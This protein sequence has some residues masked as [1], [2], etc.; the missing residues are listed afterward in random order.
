MISLI[1][2]LLQLLFGGK[3]RPRPTARPGRPAPIASG[4]AAPA[5]PMTP[6]AAPERAA[7]IGPRLQA[8]NL[9]PLA[10]SEL[11]RSLRQRGLSVWSI[12]GGASWWGRRDL[13][14]PS[15]DERTNL[16]D[17]GMIGRG[18]ASADELA[19][20]HRVGDEML[21]LD[22]RRDGGAAAAEA[23]VQDDR[24]ERA[25]RKQQKKDA[26]AR[27]R[28]ERAAAIAARRAGDI[29]FL[30]RG[31]SKGL[32]DRTADAARLGGAGLPVLATPADVAAALQLP[33]PQLRWL[34]FHAE[35]T[36]RPHY[37]RFTVPKRSGGTRDLAA[38]MPRLRA[39]QD[40]ILANLLAKVPTHAAAH[41]FVP[42]RS[43]VSNAV[44]HLQALAVVNCDLKDFFP[45]IHVH[46]VRGCFEELGYSPAAATILALLCTEAPRRLVEYAGR[47]LHVATGPRC[48]PQGAPTSPA[49]SNLIA[50]RLD[51]RC[52]G[53]ANKLG[54]TYTRYADDLSF[55]TTEPEALARIGYLL[56]RIR[57]I[58]QDE[59]FTVNEKKT[60]VLR[61][62]SCQ[63]VTGIVVNGAQP[64]IPRETVRRLRAILHQ[65]AKTGLEAQNRD[66]HPDFANHVAGMLA[67]VRMVS[68]QQAE[69]LVAAWR[70]LRRDET[71]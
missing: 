26:A 28:A 2:R 59:G 11:K 65:A 9:T 39:T 47:P 66:G 51:A 1:Q 34:A 35:A 60:R 24:A 44:P 37:V 14:P 48:L 64:H 70:Q 58:A 22:P 69:P 54:F 18:L 49:L 63:R 8:P 7:G 71:A 21:R 40:W 27:R 45:T 41:G 56:A 52:Q 10:G 5:R 30:G 15:T 57:H 46:R 29:V 19:A 12:F 36:A 16:I 55:S 33:I 13:V 38:P 67:W 62:S 4:S 53:I 43:T 20:M 61:P 23:A 17:R 50:R 6:P 25:Q 31:V 68:P 42:G 32:A 3:P